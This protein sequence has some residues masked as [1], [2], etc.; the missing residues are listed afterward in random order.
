MH[1]SVQALPYSWPLLGLG[2]RVKHEVDVKAAGW[3]HRIWINLKVA[4]ADGS[5]HTILVECLRVNDMILAECKSALN[6]PLPLPVRQ[7]ITSQIETIRRIYRRVAG[8]LGIA[9]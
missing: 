3:L 2:G 8:A 6:E 9:I 5:E 4:L 7:Q 1:S